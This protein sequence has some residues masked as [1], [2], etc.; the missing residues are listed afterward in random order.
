MRADW[1]AALICSSN[2]CV[3]VNYAHEKANLKIQYIDFPS[4]KA[5]RAEELTTRELAVVLDARDGQI[6]GLDRGELRPNV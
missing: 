5:A 4:D 1:I 2:V 6:I 3:A